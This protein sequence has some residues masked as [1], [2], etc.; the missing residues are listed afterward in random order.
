MMMMLTCLTRT[1]N[2]GAIAATYINLKTI[3]NRDWSVFSFSE[4]HIEY[5]VISSANPLST[6]KQGGLSHHY[7][8]HKAAQLKELAQSL[9]RG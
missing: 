6:T 7:S 2:S 4:I 9:W 5:K 3:G 1:Q 8:H